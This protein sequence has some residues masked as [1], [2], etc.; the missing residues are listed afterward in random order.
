MRQAN[1]ENVILLMPFLYWITKITNT[2]TEYVLTFFFP[3]EHDCTKAPQCYVTLT[4]ST[5]L[6]NLLVI[7]LRSSS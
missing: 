1:D 4:F 7:L 2:Y 5:L 6:Q 3:L